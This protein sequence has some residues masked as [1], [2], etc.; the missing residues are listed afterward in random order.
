MRIMIVDD[1]RM[2]TEELYDICTSHHAIH[3][4]VTFDNPADALVFIFWFK[5][6][7]E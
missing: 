7:K 3:E 4:A 5:Y 2:A 6:Y 1:E